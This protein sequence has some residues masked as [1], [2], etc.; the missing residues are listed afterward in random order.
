MATGDGDIRATAIA[1]GYDN[2]DDGD[3]RRRYTG[4]G[5]I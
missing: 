5:D 3:R 4:D 2:D 1:K